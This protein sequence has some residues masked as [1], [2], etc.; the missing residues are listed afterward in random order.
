MNP[1]TLQDPPKSAQQTGKQSVDSG[2]PS[3]TNIDSEVAEVLGTPIVVDTSDSAMHV[4]DSHEEKAGKA[5]EPMESE[6]MQIS[7]SEEKMTD[8]RKPLIRKPA[9]KRRLVL[10]EKIIR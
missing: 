6:P 5:V 1:S 8:Q 2:S 10:P 7:G 4:A 3:S 9:I